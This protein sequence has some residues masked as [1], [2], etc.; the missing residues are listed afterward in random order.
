M[1]ILV[2]T[3]ISILRFYRYIKYIDDISVDILIQNFSDV[4]N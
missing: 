4:K 2:I 3:N 1:K